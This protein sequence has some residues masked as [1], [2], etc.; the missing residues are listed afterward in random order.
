MYYMKKVTFTLVLLFEG[1][2]SANAQ[3]W[4]DLESVDYYLEGISCTT[5]AG[6][7]VTGSYDGDRGTWIGQINR[8]LLPTLVE[9]NYVNNPEEGSPLYGIIVLVP[10]AN[11]SLYSFHDLGMFFPYSS[12]GDGWLYYDGTGIFQYLQDPILDLGEDEEIPDD[13]IYGAYLQC[14]VY[15]LALSS[16]PPTIRLA[17]YSL[18][19]LDE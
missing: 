5:I 1:L 2:F 14:G 10:D 13:Y 16:A 9:T 12:G 3:T 17:I 6:F 18:N 7:D 11:N 4:V 15:E 8:S 19:N